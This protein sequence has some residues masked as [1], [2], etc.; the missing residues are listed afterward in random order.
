[1][2]QAQK[3]L[4]DH[5]SITKLLA[6]VGGSMGG[7]QVMDWSILFPETVRSAVVIA[8]TPRLSPQAIAFDEVGRHAIASDP[9][10]R[11]G[12]YYGA[13][14]PAGGLAIARMIG[15][16]TYLSEESMMEKF[17]RKK[18]A[19]E[20]DGME[21]TRQFA[22]GSYLHYKGDSFVKRFDANSYLYITRAMDEYDLEKRCGSLTE[23]FESVKS[24]FLVISFT[25]DW[26]FPTSQSKQ[27]V[28]ALMNNNKDVSFCE[29]KS[30]Y[31]HDAF[32]L[33]SAQITKIISGFLEN[34]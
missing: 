6:V 14:A 9:Q 32:L 7:M 17:G 24:K 10:W 22:V 33:E 28:K 16:I 30:S 12:N 25:S 11:E 4:I 26:L 34:V 5:L 8:S 1:M 15:H 20:D 21:F 13:E 3:S 2:V 19:T 27:I 31:G 18:M 23:A 29:I